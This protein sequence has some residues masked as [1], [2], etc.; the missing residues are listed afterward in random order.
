MHAALQML[1]GECAARGVDGHDLAVEQ[2]RAIEGGCDGR[3]RVGHLGELVGLLVAE[4]RPDPD[5]G[6]GAW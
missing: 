3:Q 2:Q 6:S 5:T 4:A 1:E